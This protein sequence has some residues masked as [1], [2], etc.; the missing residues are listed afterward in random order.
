MVKSI[1]RNKPFFHSRFPTLQGFLP[2]DSHHYQLALY[3]SGM[4][5]L[6]TNVHVGM[7][8]PWW[9]SGRAGDSCR[10]LLIVNAGDSGSVSVLGRSSREKATPPV[11]LPRES[12][13]Q[14]SLTG[15]GP[16]G[17]KVSD[18][19][20]SD[21]A[22]THDVWSRHPSVFLLLCSLQASCSCHTWAGLVSWEHLPVTAFLLPGLPEP[23]DPL[24]RPSSLWL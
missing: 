3:L 7:G 1:R 20:G 8:L 17:R 10:C 15:Y 18:V 14:R 5:H 16:Q 24:I 6:C 11:F 13:G 9:L 21:L 2:R 22:R 19:T 23:C 12:H 4:S